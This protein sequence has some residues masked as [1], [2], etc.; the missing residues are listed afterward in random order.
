MNHTDRHGSDGLVDCVRPSCVQT[1]LQPEMWNG[2]KGEGELSGF[3]SHAHST[4][5]SGTIVALNGCALGVSSLQVALRTAKHHCRLIG[6]SARRFGRKTKSINDNMPLGF[7]SP[8]SSGCVKS[9]N[10]FMK[11]PLASLGSVVAR[12]CEQSCCPFRGDELPAGAGC[13]QM[14]ALATQPGG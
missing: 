6:F 10:R 3:W 11:H 1:P 9:N 14:G 5:Q 4:F 2:L 12:G 13:D 7:G 8:Q